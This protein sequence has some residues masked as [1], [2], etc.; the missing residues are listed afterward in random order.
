LTRR[1]QDDGL[2]QFYLG[3][4]DRFPDSHL[5]ELV[6]QEM[7]AERRI[8]I[9]NHTVINFGSDSSSA[10]I[11]TRAFN[12]RSPPASRSGARTTAR[13]GRSAASRPISRRNAGWHAGSESKTR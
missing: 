9:G 6:A 12:E 3:L 4:R 13:R 8:R 7:D 1:L 5:K 10:S 11:K 2:V